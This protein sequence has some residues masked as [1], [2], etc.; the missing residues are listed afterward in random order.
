MIKCTVNG[1]EGYPS[2]TSE[3]KV[4][5]ENP[6]VKKGDSFTMEINFPMDIPENANLFGNLHRMDVSKRNISYS[7][8]MLFA[9]N[10]LI[11]RGSGRV[12]EITETTVKLQILG[13]NADIKYKSKFDQVFID[14]IDTY[15]SVNSKYTHNHSEN[16]HIPTSEMVMVRSEIRSKGYVG[17]KTKYV[18]QPVYD[19]DNDLIANAT[20]IAF[21]SSS[22]DT[23]LLNIA[24]QPNLMMVLRCV[25]Q[26]MGYSIKSNAYD[27][28]P[29]NELIIANARQTV[30]IAH[31]LPHWTV[32]TFL[33][34]FRKLFNA[35]FIFDDTSKQVS[36]VRCNELDTS[37]DVSYEVVEKY[38]T[39]YDEDGIEY[40]A[41][42]NIQFDLQG[43]DRTLDDMPAALLQKFEVLEYGTWMQLE[44]AF[45]SMSERDRHTHLFK[46]NSGYYFYGHEYNENDEDTGRFILK[47]FGFFGPLYRDVNSET[48]VKLRM[49]PA[50]M[51]KTVYKWNYM[52][53]GGEVDYYAKGYNDGWNC[54]LI[55]PN[56]NNP[57]GNSYIDYEEKGYVSVSNILEDGESKD[58]EETEDETVM[59][60]IWVDGYAYNPPDSNDA[61]YGIPT[62]TN[63]YRTGYQR[64]TYSLSLAN[65]G[66]NSHY[67]GELHRGNIEL[68]TTVDSN[69]E[70]CY[71]FLM[72]GLPDPTR[73]YVFRN[74]RYLCSKVEVMITKDGIDRLKTGYFYEVK[75]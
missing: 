43:Y 74:K 41:G 50:G 47:P 36:I 52:A 51:R 40:L 46:C 13:G 32:E 37:N 35:S 68:E 15:P 60:L 42:S 70:I 64:L 5:K 8:C 39:N 30:N 11:I 63:D 7:D 20:M 3:I 55:L 27:V 61:N 65:C 48:F 67:I 12:T 6:Y 54:L 45:S 25:L 57:E 16:D 58:T 75:L 33:D 59:S 53:K 31:A 38:K 21:T 4:T 17:D 34:E 56:V 71:Q 28:A 29:W 18:F 22:Q 66:L 72:E 73:I 23:C 69:T 26:Y 2:V 49:Q 24:V 10:I 1:V 14:R 62:S 9:D 44:N 19:I